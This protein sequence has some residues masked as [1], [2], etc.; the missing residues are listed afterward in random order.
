MDVQELRTRVEQHLSGVTSENAAV[1][2]RAFADW[3]ESK[4]NEEADIQAHI[5]WL[6]SRGYTVTKN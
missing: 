6:Q 5:D 1:T 4:Q 2:L 3:V